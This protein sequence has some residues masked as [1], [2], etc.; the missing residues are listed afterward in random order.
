M[1][2]ISNEFNSAALGEQVKNALFGAG[3]VHFWKS[4]RRHID[5]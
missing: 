5:A 1:G 3:N 2:V 4:G